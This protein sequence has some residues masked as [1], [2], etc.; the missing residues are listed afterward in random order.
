MTPHPHSLCSRGTDATSGGRGDRGGRGGGRGGARVGRTAPGGRGGATGEEQ[1]FDGQGRGGGRGMGRGSGI[2]QRGGRASGRGSGG[3]GSPDEG[4]G[5]DAPWM[6]LGAGDG[7]D[8]F[9]E[10]SGPSRGGGRPQSARPGGGRLQ[11]PPLPPAPGSG[12]SLADPVVVFDRQQAPGHA[13]SVPS[14]LSSLQQLAGENGPA[15]KSSVLALP[16]DLT[17]DMEPRRGG[18]GGF[19]VLPGPPASVRPLAAGPFAYSPANSVPVASAVAVPPS[20]IAAMWADQGASAAS[21]VMGSTA[22]GAVTPGSSWGSAAFPAA[23]AAA[24]STAGGS[25]AREG[26][27]LQ[28]GT[29]HTMF[30]TGPFSGFGAAPPPPRGTFESQAA[31][32]FGGLTSGANWSPHAVPGAQPFLPSNKPPDWS[33]PGLAVGISP[34][35]PQP[36][37]G[38][39]TMNAAAAAAFA[40]A[41]PGRGEASSASGAGATFGHLQNSA[42]PNFATA[43]GQ[44]P[45]PMHHGKA[46]GG[47]FGLTP[48]QQHQQ[49]QQHV[50]QQQH[51]I[52]GVKGANG[53]RV[54]PVAEALAILPDDIYD[55]KP[56]PGPSAQSA[57]PPPLS[58]AKG[59]PGAPSAD[60][61]ALG[62][63]GRGRGG[64]RGKGGGRG[65]PGDDGALRLEATGGVSREAPPGP[66]RGFA[67]RNGRGAGRSSV[68][69]QAP[70][71]GQGLSPPHQPTAPPPVAQGSPSLQPPQP[72]DAPVQPNGV[73]DGGRGV[74]GRGG[75]GG[76]GGGRGGGGRGAGKPT[77]TK[78]PITRGEAP[79]VPMTDA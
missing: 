79:S 45:R 48:Q 19:T 24:V 22:V 56:P 15:G 55:S 74:G 3:R 27:Q 13:A 72:Y 18:G 7:P 49:Q 57:K 25:G 73:P 59:P 16:V 28:S 30:A 31:G 12:P 33:V 47:P 5:A 71:Q 64:G 40:A 70:S 46:A 51:Q 41:S 6:P 43:P 65:V 1:T 37:L 78:A 63:S 67:G 9:G 52:V 54:T 20:G 23:N 2:A 10:S 29:P 77:G 60:R 21:K 44:P 11:D 75:R 58:V 68:P 36:A 62:A 76:R 4:E 42:L 32:P 14:S 50:Q 61:P 38:G 69:V 34:S 8:R 26:P 53:H 35:G 39:L 66:G 17:L